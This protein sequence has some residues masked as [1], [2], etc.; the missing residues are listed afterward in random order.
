MI[1]QD[2]CDIWSIVQP[3]LY[4]L[5]DKDNQHYV[6]E[7]NRCEVKNG[8][9]LQLHHSAVKAS[10]DILRTLRSSTDSVPIKVGVLEKLSALST[11]PTFAAEF[12]IQQG[13]DTVIEMIEDERCTDDQLRFVM[14]S[15]VELME[16][17][18]VSWDILGAGFIKRNIYCITNPTLV[19]SVAVQSALS[20]LENIVNHSVNFEVIQNEVPFEAALRLLQQQHSAGATTTTTTSVIPQNTIALINAFFQRADDARKRTIATTFSST[21]YRNALQAIVNETKVGAEMAHQLYALQTHMLGQLEPRMMATLV[22]A[23]DQDAYLDKIKELRRIAFDDYGGDSASDAA[24]SVRSKQNPHAVCYKKL[25]FK[26]DIN[27]TQDFN[28]TPPGLLALDCMVYFA[29]NYVQNYTKVVHEYSCR[30]DEHECPFGRTSIELVKV[31]CEIL[32]I[33]EPPSSEGQDYYQM[34]FSH[35]HPF[36]ELFCVCIMVLNKTWKDMRA[37][38]EDFAKVFSVLR[39]QISRTLRAR[40]KHL[41]DFKVQIGQMTYAAITSLRQQEQTSKEECASTAS[42]IVSLKKKITPDILRLIEAQRLNYLVDG[43]RFSKYQGMTRSKD[44]FWYA[45]LSANHK[46]LQFGDC[47][48]KAVQLDDKSTELAVADFKQLLVKQECPH[49]INDRKKAA[50]LRFSIGY[51]KSVSEENATLD[52]VA[53]DEFTFAYWTDGVNALLKHPMTSDRMQEELDTLLS[54]EIK[55]RLLDTESVDISAEPPPIPNDPEN[56]DFCFES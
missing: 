10:A 19:P 12:I 50:N 43:T 42:A 2:L 29:R 52:F 9:I 4:E 20:N 44:K 47:E 53:P 40:P 7:R 41:D 34:F 1:I 39:E 48:E 27:P 31:M 14:E 25:G 8:S 30:G 6:T 23:P 56:Y 16:H 49:D 54:M 51:K 13:L 33:G 21:N 17:G 32:Q 38:S 18:N 46:T 15:F 35:D 36:E 11:D 3:E 37:T 55:L 45:R 26:Y 5:K 28:E 24:S 22:S